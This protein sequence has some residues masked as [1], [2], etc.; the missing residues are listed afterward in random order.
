M[1]FEI[2]CS[3]NGFLATCLD[4]ED[5]L[6]DDQIFKAG[7]EETKELFEWMKGHIKKEHSAYW[8]QRSLE[9]TTP[10]L[11]TYGDSLGRIDR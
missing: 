8:C 7:P 2:R 10:L 5:D 11:P 6:D 1:Y 3:K 9:I 4:G